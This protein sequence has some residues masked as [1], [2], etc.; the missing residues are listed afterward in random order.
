MSS[1]V[2]FSYLLIWVVGFQRWN[3]AEKHSQTIDSGLIKFIILCILLYFILE[4]FG[5]TFLFYVLLL[6]NFSKKANCH[7][8]FQLCYLL[9]L[10]YFFYDSNPVLNDNLI[11]ILMD[12][13]MNQNIVRNSRTDLKMFSES[14]PFCTLSDDYKI[15]CSIFLIAKITHLF[16]LTQLHWVWDL[17]YKSGSQIMERIVPNNCVSTSVV[18]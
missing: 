1:C 11:N 16:Y 17:L 10:W 7:I 14:Y 12:K 13:W 9:T 2:I 3:M 5:K 4:R 6:Y 15:L 8:L 18:V